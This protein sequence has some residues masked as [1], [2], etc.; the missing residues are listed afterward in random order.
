MRHGQVLG[1]D[2]C[3]LRV[4]VRLSAGRADEIGRWGHGGGVE[5]WRGSGVEGAVTLWGGRHGR[6]ARGWNG[7]VCCSSGSGSSSSFLGL[8]GGGGLLSNSG[9][10]VSCLLS[11]LLLLVRSWAELVGWDGR[12]KEIVCHGLLGK[13]ESVGELALGVV[14]SSLLGLLDLGLLGLLGLDGLLLSLKTFLVEKFNGLADTLDLFIV[15]S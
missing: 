2:G 12:W 6:E 9:L 8:M 3:L 15:L 4:S 13:S 7:R 11:I 5:D 14:L 10:V 1:A